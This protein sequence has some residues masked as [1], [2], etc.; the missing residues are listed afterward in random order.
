LIQVWVAR[1]RECIRHEFNVVPERNFVR[2][3]PVVVYF[4]KFV[5]FPAWCSS[6]QFLCFEFPTSDL[7]R[8]ID[9]IFWV[10]WFGTESE[11]FPNLVRISAVLSE[12]GGSRW[13]AWGSNVC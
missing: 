6:A 9:L 4:L 1:E 11:D 5:P 2:L 3:R 7:F 8:T 12:I 10:V 13:A